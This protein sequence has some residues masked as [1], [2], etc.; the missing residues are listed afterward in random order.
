MSVMVRSRS[1]S[2]S[3]PV[4]LIAAFLLQISGGCA[5][6]SRST[7]QS[8]AATVA[9]HTAATREDMKPLQAQRLPPGAGLKYVNRAIKESGWKIPGL[10]EMT[11]EKTIE[12]YLTKKI[13][14]KINL[15]EFR[16]AKEIEAA[17]DVYFIDK[18]GAL[19]VSPTRFKFGRVV[20]FN[21]EDRPFCYIV[22][23]NL[24]DEMSNDIPTLTSLVYYDEDGDGS[25]EV[26]ESGRWAV[27]PRL[28]PWAL[29]QAKAQ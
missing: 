6:Y 22:N 5:T 1:G 14:S 18:S 10:S 2:L 9:E 28:P 29:K 24:P 15:T 3:G 7:A 23:A 12:T 19:V 8:N 16:G 21:V 4:A 27:E 17:V 13:S 20:R 25:F 26:F 11:N